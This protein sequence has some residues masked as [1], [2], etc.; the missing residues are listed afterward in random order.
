MKS[1]SVLLLLI[2]VSAVLAQLFLPWWSVVPLCLGL[3][4]WRST[5][6][7]GAFLAGLLGAGLS[8]WLPAVW[9]NTHGAGLLATRVA[10]LIPLGGNTGLLVLVSGLLLG[11]AGGL[12]ALS[13]ALFRWAFAPRPAAPAKA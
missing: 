8:W 4:A 3:A 11:L 12:A 1:F 10:T 5:S 7:G 9:L 2:L 13:G 6:I